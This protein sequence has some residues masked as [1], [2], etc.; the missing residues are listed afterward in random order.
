[1]PTP[2]LK[3]VP[4]ALC[5]AVVTGCS[6]GGTEP[7]PATA[8]S[9]AGHWAITDAVRAVLDAGRCVDAAS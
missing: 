3:P 6:G 4:L 7:A 2:E 9:D 8:P 1:M 5:A